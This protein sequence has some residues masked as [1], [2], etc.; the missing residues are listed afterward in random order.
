MITVVKQTNLNVQNAR[1][2]QQNA[3]TIENGLVIMLG[4]GLKG[5]YVV[6]M[7][8]VMLQLANANV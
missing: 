1:Q 7:S 6:P 2:V 4:F 5:N 3:K 8:N